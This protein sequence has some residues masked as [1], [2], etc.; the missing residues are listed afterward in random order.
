MISAS[1]PTHVEC[2]FIAVMTNMFQI[3]AI[4]R[5]STTRC[6]IIT[7]QSWRKITQV[8]DETFSNADLTGVREG[9]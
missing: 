8:L 3:Y 1:P 9:M 2:D 5:N 7:F 6:G 4:N